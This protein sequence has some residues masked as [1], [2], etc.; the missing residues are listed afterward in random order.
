M[1][2]TINDAN[3]QGSATGTLEG[4]TRRQLHQLRRPAPAAIIYGIPLKAGTP[5]LDATATFNNAAVAGAFFVYI[6]AAGTVLSAGS[7]TLSVTFTPT[8]TTDYSTPGPATTTITV[9]SATLD[10]TANNAAKVY[11]TAN[12][13]FTGSVTG[14]Q[15][16]DSC[17]ESF[18]TTATISSN[19]GSYPI[20]PSVTGT[21]LSDYT[22]VVT[23]GTLT[24]TQAASTTSLIASATSITPGEPLTLTATVASTTTGTPTG[25]VTFYDNTIPLGTVTL[26]AGVASYTTSA[27]APGIA[28]KISATYSGDMNFTASSTTASLT[29]TVAPLEFTLTVNGADFKSVFPGSTTTYTLAVAPLYG[30]YA[31]TVNFAISGLPSGVTA[32]FLTR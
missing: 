27:L 8:D 16:N 13:V 11:G 23:D 3:Y 32:A 24:I 19:V 30:S 21:D 25:S 7:H 14:T 31:G 26:N 1:V 4:S 29:I 15:N 9:N 2:G 20:A 6:P 12:P 22:Q 17:T 18:T 28:H 5:Q 10:V